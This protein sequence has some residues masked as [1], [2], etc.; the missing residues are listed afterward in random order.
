MSKFLARQHTG[1]NVPPAL[2]NIGEYLVVRTADKLGVSRQPKI[3]NVATRRS[4]IT[5]L[6]IEHGDDGRRV[7][8]EQC[9]LGLALSQP[10]LRSFALGDVADDLRAA[11]DAAFGISHGRDGD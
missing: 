4:E 9:Q 8:D 5:H 1:M 2:W 6:I 11:D 7:L 10:R 3:G